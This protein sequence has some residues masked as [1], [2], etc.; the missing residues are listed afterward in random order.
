MLAPALHRRNCRFLHRLLMGI[1][2]SAPGLRIWGSS[3]GDL[4]QQ[5]L[6]TGRK[7][8][9]MDTI[10]DD[11]ATAPQRAPRRRL[12]QGRRRC[13]GCCRQVLYRA[14]SSASVSRSVTPSRADPKQQ[15]PSPAATTPFWLPVPDHLVPAAR[16][17]LPP[18]QY[19]CRA[20][21]SLQEREAGRV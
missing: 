19:R 9:P 3:P 11:I 15:L 13:P 12:G 17:H 4:F 20:V 2:M 14:F 7:R 21:L 1:R 18:K 16:H 10:F 6:N 8:R 5:S